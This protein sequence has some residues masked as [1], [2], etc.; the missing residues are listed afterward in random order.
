MYW[1]AGEPV[2]TAAHGGRHTALTLHAGL[3]VGWR[4]AGPRRCIGVWRA[5]EQTR[6][7]CPHRAQVTGTGT[8]AQCSSCATVDTG[9]ALARDL[10]RD[11]DREF[12][13]YLAWFGPGLHKVGLTAAERKADRLLEQAALAYALLA[14]GQ[15]T[16]VRHAEQLISSWGLAGERVTGR[17]KM[18]CW[19][20]LPVAAERAAHV[21]RAAA[22]VRDGIGW[23]DGLQLV[24]PVVVDQV[25]RFGL[26]CLPPTFG[27]VTGVRAGSVLAGT[28]AALIGRYLLIGAGQ[29]P[30][31]LLDARRL[32]GWTIAPTDGP[33]QG[34]SVHARTHPRETHGDQEPLF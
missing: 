10:W 34:L 25:D 2:L 16:L 6:Q 13:L 14:R 32:A 31:M 24:D 30:P 27:E 9:R 26:A 5:A 33:C 19:W 7:S 1:Q 28:I 21:E 8:D 11:D 29:T 3:Q 15:L 4:L 18:R 17:A 23:P 20:Q 22:R 12:V